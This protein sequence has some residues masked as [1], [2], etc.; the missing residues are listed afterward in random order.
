MLNALANVIC[1]D[2]A[3]L[4]EIVFVLRTDAR[5]L[6]SMEKIIG[7]VAYTGPKNGGKSFINMRL[8]HFLGDHPEKL[9]K[10][11][12]GKYLSCTLRD[13][14]QAGQPVTNSFRGKKLISFKEFAETPI[15]PETLKNILDPQDGNVDA[16]HHNNKPGEI[17][18]FPISF[19][20]TGCGNQSISLASAVGKDNGC[21]GKVHEIRTNYNLV[22]VPDPTNKTQRLCDTTLPTRA[23]QGEFDGELFFWARVMYKTITADV[24]KT[25]H[26]SPVPPTLVVS[27]DVMSTTV[28]T[29]ILKWFDINTVVSTR[30]LSTPVCDIMKRVVQDINV[31]SIDSAVWSACGLGDNNRDSPSSS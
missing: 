29:A 4:N 16:R 2:D 17:T 26:M 14:A 15:Q 21:G 12:G 19:V 20:L 23:R 6:A 31:G 8:V 27:E 28:V 3:D 30:E 13:D 11:V 7:M 25:R 1:N 9:A 22:A 24:C 5:I 10:Q 18:S